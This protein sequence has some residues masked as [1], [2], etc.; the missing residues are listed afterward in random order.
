MDIRIQNVDETGE[1]KMFALIK[2]IIRY[3]SV[4]LTV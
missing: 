3:N 2:S 4:L 1:V